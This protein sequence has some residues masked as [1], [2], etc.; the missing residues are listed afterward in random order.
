R[1]PLYFA[2]RRSSDLKSHDAEEHHLREARGVLERAGG[3]D[4][5]LAG[6]HPVHFVELAGDARKLLRRLAERFMERLGQEPGFE[7]VGVVQELALA[8]DEQ[9]A[10]FLV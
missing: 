4:F 1:T 6:V 10:A 5:S 3:L 7:A 8:A 2:T 9:R